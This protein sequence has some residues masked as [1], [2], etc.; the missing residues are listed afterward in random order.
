MCLMAPF[1]TS[2]LILI[3][4]IDTNTATGVSIKC[5]FPQFSL[6]IILYYKPL[7]LTFNRLW[8]ISDISDFKTIFT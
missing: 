5:I 4:Y 2:S 7:F 1:L 3:N 8:N 6:L